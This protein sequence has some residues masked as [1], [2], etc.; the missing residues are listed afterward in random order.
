MNGSGLKPSASV[1]S[2][3]PP[4]A[5][6]STSRSMIGTWPT[7]S[8]G[9][10]VVSV[11]GRSRVPKPPTSTT[12]RISRLWWS[13]PA[14]W[15]RWSSS[16]VG[17]GRMVAPEPVTLV[18]PW[19][20][21][22]VSPGASVVVLAITAPPSAAPSVGSCAAQSG[23]GMLAPFGTKATVNTMPSLVMRMS[24]MSVTTSWNVFGSV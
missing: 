10:G 4:W 7:G 6:L 23:C 17:D 19:S 3:T 5:R 16:T 18:S 8:I 15:W 21:A 9:F 11:S 1:T 14:S 24:L 13:S 12:A 2:V 20:A 22:D